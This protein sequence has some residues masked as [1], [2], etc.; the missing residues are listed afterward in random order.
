M[1]QKRHGPGVNVTYRRCSS[2]DSHVWSTNFSSCCHTWHDPSNV[3]GC[4]LTLTG[5][6]SRGTFR[7]DSTFGD[8]CSF[9][10]EESLFSLLLLLL[11]LRRRETVCLTLC[12]CLSVCVCVY[13]WDQQQV[14][15]SALPPITYSTSLPRSCVHVQVSGDD[16]RESDSPDIVSNFI[17]NICVCRIFLEHFLIFLVLFLMLPLAPWLELLWFNYR[18]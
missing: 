12:V 2:T 15:I 6:I 13:V 16:Q 1:K 17:Y 18:H 11:L 7:V 9:L 14:P 4:L 8:S 10:G 5:C 3:D